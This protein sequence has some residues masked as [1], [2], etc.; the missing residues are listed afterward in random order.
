MPWFFDSA[1]PETFLAIAQRPVRPSLSDNEVGKPEWV[2]SE[3]NGPA[4]TPPVNA[5][6]PP[7]READA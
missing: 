6:P 4:C 3:L 5:S 1:G 2:I 7:L